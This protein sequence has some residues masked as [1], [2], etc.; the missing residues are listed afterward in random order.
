ML[1]CSK[2]RNNLIQRNHRFIKRHRVR[3]TSFYRI[4]T[5]GA[6]L[7]GVNIAHAIHKRNR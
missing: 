5:A 1:Q 2:Y 3:S 7:S 4:Q 6:T